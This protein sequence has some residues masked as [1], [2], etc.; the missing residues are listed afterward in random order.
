MNMTEKDDVKYRTN[1]K[2]RINGEKNA[3]PAQISV[4]AERQAI[5]GLYKKQPY[6]TA[7]FNSVNGRKGI[8]VTYRNISARRV[9]CRI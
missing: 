3:F 4:T 2:A 9:K 7:F 5:T 6:K 1:E 8:V